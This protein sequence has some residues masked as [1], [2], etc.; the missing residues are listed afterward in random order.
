[1]NATATAQDIPFESIVPVMA[2]PKTIYEK[3][4]KE[5]RYDAAVIEYIVTGPDG[6]VVE[7]GSKKERDY[8]DFLQEMKYEIDG[9]KRI[10]IDLNPFVIK[11]EFLY[12][13]DIATQK[14]FKAALFIGI[15]SLVVGIAVMMMAFRANILENIESVRGALSGRIAT[16]EKS[17]TEHAN[18]IAF[19]EAKNNALEKD[20]NAIKKGVYSTSYAAAVTPPVSA[21]EPTVKGAANHTAGDRLADKKSKRERAKKERKANAINGHNPVDIDQY[22]KKFAGRQ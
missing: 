15:P 11:K 19:I 16:V 5:S 13:A 20:L 14:R 8:V 9:Y 4:N 2:K 7:T 18:R 17:S 22:M 6:M 10:R 3:W 1:M 21:V 12:E